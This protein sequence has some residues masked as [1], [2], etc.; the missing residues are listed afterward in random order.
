MAMTVKNS[1]KGEFEDIWNHYNRRIK[2]GVNVEQELVTRALYVRRQRLE[3]EG[4]EIRFLLEDARR[5]NNPEAEQKYFE[6]TV[7]IMQALS[8]IQ[9]ELQQAINLL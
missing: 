3:R 5:S 6:R 2:P 4:R 9:R 8:I 1:L 7:P